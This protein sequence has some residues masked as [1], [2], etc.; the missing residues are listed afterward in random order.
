[1]L[2]RGSY[3]HTKRKATRI[4]R[5]VENVHGV[6]EC[7]RDIAH[8]HFRCL[9][10]AFYTR[11]CHRTQEARSALE[12]STTAPG[13]VR[14]LIYRI[15]SPWSSASGRATLIQYTSRLVNGPE[16]YCPLGTVSLPIVLKPRTSS[17]PYAFPAQQFW[18][19]VSAMFR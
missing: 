8:E 14:G 11:P 2:T 7:H 12:I 6:S 16:A 15:A 1:M 19:F 3:R 17:S 13:R 10:R 4:P 5:N 18:E 9:K